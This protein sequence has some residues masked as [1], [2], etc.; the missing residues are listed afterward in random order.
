MI[1]NESWANLFWMCCVTKSINILCA[2]IKQMLLHVSV[3]MLVD[4]GLF[5]HVVDFISSYFFISL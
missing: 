5:E 3:R 2:E 1:K 4:N